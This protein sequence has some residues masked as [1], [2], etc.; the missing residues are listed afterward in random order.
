MRYNVLGLDIWTGE[1]GLE[2][3][4]EIHENHW[5]RALHI[6]FLAFVYL[7]VYRGIPAILGI[8]DYRSK[9][10]IGGIMSI[11]GAFYATFDQIGALWTILCNLPMG[12]IAYK[13]LANS[14]QIS[15]WHHV[16]ISMLFMLSA[17]LLQEVVGHTLWEEVNSR[18]TFSYVLNA[19]MYSPLYCSRYIWT[20]FPYSVIPT[21]IYINSL[22][23]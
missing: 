6:A 9:W 21:L 18:M 13:Q 23:N 19:I 1:E 11:Y 3:Y 15:R 12:I 4:E 14:P 5:N 16:K 20:Y 17:L 2:V 7:G 10:I 22:L 8:T